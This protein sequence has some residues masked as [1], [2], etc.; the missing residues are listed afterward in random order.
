MEMDRNL[1]LANAEESAFRCEVIG[2][3][4]LFVQPF[5]VG[6]RSSTKVIEVRLLRNI[7]LELSYW[8]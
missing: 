1:Y 8:L 6:S 2:S 4:K 3:S 7:V 5:S